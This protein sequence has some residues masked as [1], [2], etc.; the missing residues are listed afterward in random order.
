MRQRPKQAALEA[1]CR[2]DH[3][4]NVDPVRD[5]PVDLRYPA[6][7]RKW[8]GG[9]VWGISNN[10]NIKSS[11]KV[12]KRKTVLMTSSSSGGEKRRRGQQPDN[13][14]P[15]SRTE[16]A[17]PQPSARHRRSPQSARRPKAMSPVRLALPKLSWNRGLRNDRNR[18]PSP[19]PR[20]L[21]QAIPTGMPM[22]RQLRQCRGGGRAG[23]GCGFSAHL[24]LADAGGSPH[25]PLS[26]SQRVSRAHRTSL[27]GLSFL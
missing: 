7:Y 1:L 24:G 27:K 5:Q 2:E 4:R 21:P 10:W 13:L 20:Y 18:C 14:A 9:P 23:A 25:S 12:R 3:A 15:Q 26:R 6:V 22:S 17:K 19:P 16:E 8:G 11:V